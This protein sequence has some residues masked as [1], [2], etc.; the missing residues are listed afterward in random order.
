MHPNP[1]PDLRN[2]YAILFDLI[3]KNFAHIQNPRGG[4][5]GAHV[6]GMM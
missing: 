5:S 4:D 1:E 3:H 6:M 2:N